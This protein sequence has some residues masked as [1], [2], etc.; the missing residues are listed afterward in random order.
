[1]QTHRPV[2]IVLWVASARIDSRRR[3]SRDGRRGKT[4]S[5]STGRSAMI[6]ERLMRRCA[7]RSQ[8]LRA[9]LGGIFGAGVVCATIVIVSQLLGLPVHPGVA[10]TLGAVAGASYLASHR[11]R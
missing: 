7:F 3:T 1:M 9:V 2:S 5:D 8:M 11:D 6:V 10:G 4:G